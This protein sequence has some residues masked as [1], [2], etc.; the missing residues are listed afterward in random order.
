MDEKDEGFYDTPATGEWTVET[1]TG[2]NEMKRIMDGDHVV[3]GWTMRPFSESFQKIADA[4]N[5]A[6]SAVTGRHNEVCYDYAKTLAT[7]RG[8]QHHMEACRALLNVPDD[9]VLYGAIEELQQQLAAERAKVEM[10]EGIEE[11]LREAN[12]RYYDAEVKVQ[13][14]TDALNRISEWD[15][16]EPLS[17][18]IAQDALAQVK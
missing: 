3:I 9:E 8:A 10:N 11:E 1:N 4:H 16:G 12:Q 14:L 18:E 17:A 13:T 6:I 7:A 2:S 15:K 5:A